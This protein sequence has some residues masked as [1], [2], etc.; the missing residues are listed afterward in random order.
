[1]TINIDRVEKKHV[2][3][4]VARWRAEPGYGG[5]RESTRYSILINGRAYPPKAIAAI[6]CECAGMPRPR[7]SEFEWAPNGHWRRA[8]ENLGFPTV[9]KVDAGDATTNG[10]APTESTARIEADLREIEERADSLKTTREALVQARLGQGRYRRELLARWEHRCAVTGCQ[11]PQVLRA[12]H[13]KPWHKCRDAERLDPDNG[14]P[15]VATLD[16]LF[17]AGLI[18][19]DKSGRM[20][21]STHLDENHQ[22]S[23][24]LGVPRTLSKTPSDAVAAYLAAHR[25]LVFKKE[26]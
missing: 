17:D 7:P 15:L 16:A 14:L 12:S 6:A 5:F 2:V 13:A 22:A 4:A 24:L 10:E 26:R 21:I 3:E 23:L 8:L 25:E 20:E 18:T 19:F 9:P 1:M 11:V